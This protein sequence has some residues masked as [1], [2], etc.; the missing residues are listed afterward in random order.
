MFLQ[1]F[2]DR[3]RQRGL[4]MVD[5]TNRPYVAVRLGPF[6]FFFRH[7]ALSFVAPACRRLF[8]ES[9]VVLRSTQ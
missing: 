2:R 6:K 3:R 7:F 4:A 5:M 9:M 1:N 8:R